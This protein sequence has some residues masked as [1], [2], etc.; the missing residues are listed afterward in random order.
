MG[1]RRSTRRTVETVAV[2][3]EEDRPLDPLADGEVDRSC[4]AR[5]ERDGDDLA[6][7]A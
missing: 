1:A 6:A 4:G 2:L 5:R 3:A 7:F